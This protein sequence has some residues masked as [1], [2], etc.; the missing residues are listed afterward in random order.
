MRPE[1]KLRFPD[2]P[3]LEAFKPAEAA[4]V[5]QSECGEGR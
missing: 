2:L 3:Q 4:E 5:R 1:A